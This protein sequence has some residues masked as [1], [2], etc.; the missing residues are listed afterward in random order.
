MAAWGPQCSWLDCCSMPPD[1]DQALPSLG[2][3]ILWESNYKLFYLLPSKTCGMAN[4][5][6]ELGRGQGLGLAT[7]PQYMT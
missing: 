7:T 3:F 4:D 6:L 5:K 1:P 2:I